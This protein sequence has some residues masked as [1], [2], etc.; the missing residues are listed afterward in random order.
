MAAEKPE[1]PDK[2]A[3]VPPI[4]ETETAAPAAVGGGVMRFLPLIVALVLAPVISWAVAEFILLPR[5]KAQ[6]TAAVTSMQPA[7]TGGHSLASADHPA[8]NPA[9]ATTPPTKEPKKEPA[10]KPKEGA[11]KEGGK[12]GAKAEGPAAKVV[13][14]GPNNYQFDNVVVNLAGTMG[15]RYLKASFL[16]TGKED[17]RE[18]FED[19]KPQLLDTTLNT[20]GSITLTDLEEV[21]SRNL[22]RAR[23]VAAY[24]DLLGAKV[25]EQIYFSDFVVQ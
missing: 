12:K 24:N 19:K 7:E 2:G 21:G 17:L 13:A 25:V 20:L 15:T 11:K 6:L 16:I 8:E 14:E 5:M 22:I 18:Q 4:A 9:A 10:E 1:K 23:L 3:E